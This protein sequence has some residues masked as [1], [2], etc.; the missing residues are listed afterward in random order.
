MSNFANPELR[1]NSLTSVPNFTKIEA[2][3]KYLCEY[4]VPYTKALWLIKVC[5]NSARSAATQKD[6]Y[7][8]GFAD[9]IR[10][11]APILFSRTPTTNNTAGQ[12][13]NA[14]SNAYASN[15]HSNATPTPTKPHSH[16]SN[17]GSNFQTPTKDASHL[18]LS[19]S[20]ATLASPATVIQFPKLSNPGDVGLT[21][22]QIKAK[23]NLLY[24][25]RL[26][27]WAYRDGFIPLGTLVDRFC[28]EF[29]TCSDACACLYLSTLFQFLPDIIVNYPALER[30]KTVLSHV[31]DKFS[32]KNLPSFSATSSLG[33][34]SPAGT[35]QS[36][37]P[38]SASFGSS[39]SG[40][41]SNSGARP[42]LFSLYCSTLKVLV[43]YLPD[44]F[45]PQ[46]LDM[47]R[48]YIGGAFIDHMA[49]NSDCSANSSEPESPSLFMGNGL[50]GVPSGN[51]KAPLPFSHMGRPLT[52]GCTL[53]F[54]AIN[55][56]H[57]TPSQT[58]AFH[59][60]QQNINANRV[61][62]ILDSVCYDHVCTL[63]MNSNFEGI[64]ADSPIGPV[65]RNSPSSHTMG[66]LNALDS[67]SRHLDL[68]QLYTAL[69]LTSQT[70]LASSATSNAGS[71]SG[72][73]LTPNGAV[74]T[75]G[76]VGHRETP[77]TPS[78][79]STSGFVLIGGEALERTFQLICSW[80][81]AP[82][83]TGV[84]RAYVT[85]SLIR[86]Y[87]MS[88]PHCTDLVCDSLIDFIDSL[89]CPKESTPGNGCSDDVLLVSSLLG[90]LIRNRAFS[91]D[92]YLR[93]LI[94]RGI[95]LQANANNPTA[96]KHKAYLL[97][98]PL[99]GDCKPDRLQRS[100][101]IQRYM[102]T[103]K[104]EQDLQEGIAHITNCLLR[105]SSS[106]C[107]REGG[108][109]DESINAPSGGDGGDETP[110]TVSDSDVASAEREL[111][112]Y[113]NSVTLF[114]RC[115]TGQYAISVVKYLLTQHFTPAV[116][117]L[118]TSIVS[119]SSISSSGYANVHGGPLVSGIGV[120]KV[121]PAQSKTSAIGTTAPDHIAPRGFDASLAL[122]DLGPGAEMML[123]QRLC[124]VLEQMAD[125]RSMIDFGRW[126]LDR[127][128]R[129]DLGNHELVSRCL[130]PLFQAYEHVTLALDFSMSPFLERFLILA[131]RCA[132]NIAG[133]HHPSGIHQHALPHAH[134][135]AAAFLVKFSA[136][137]A[138][139]VASVGLWAAEKGLSL[140]ALKR[141]ISPADPPTR[142]AI[143][144]MS[145]HTPPAQS[146]QSLA[147]NNLASGLQ[148]IDGS[149]LLTPSHTSPKIS[150]TQIKDAQELF[151]VLT[152]AWFRRMTFLAQT[153]SFNASTLDSISGSC[154]SSNSLQAIIAHY[155][156][157]MRPSDVR[158]ALGNAICGAKVRNLLSQVEARTEYLLVHW[159][160]SL[161]TWMYLSGNLILGL[162]AK[163][164]KFAVVGLGAQIERSFF[165]FVLLLL[166]TL[167][168][169]STAAVGGGEK[170]NFYTPARW[171]HSLGR[172]IKKKALQTF[173]SFCGLL[174]SY[175]DR[176]ALLAQSGFS[177]SAAISEIKSER[178]QSESD[179][180]MSN[181]SGLGGFVPSS[182]SGGP[183]A[184]SLMWFLGESLL[185][186]PHEDMS[187][188]FRSLGDSQRAFQVCSLIFSNAK[189][190]TM[191]PTKGGILSVATPRSHV[192]SENDD[193]DS[194]MQVDA[195]PTAHKGAWDAFT[196]AID[197]RDI[198]QVEERVNAILSNTHIWSVR[199]T[200]LQ[201]QLLL[202][203]ANDVE[204]Q[205]IAALGATTPNAV[206]PKRVNEIFASAL[207]QRLSRNILCC[208]GYEGESAR[209]SAA[210][211]AMDEDEGSCTFA[212]NTTAARGPQWSE[213]DRLFCEDPLCNSSEATVSLLKRLGAG[214][215]L[216][217]LTY[218]FGLLDPSKHQTTSRCFLS[219]ALLGPE[220]VASRNS[221][222][223]SDRLSA[224][225]VERKLI[226]LLLAIASCCILDGSSPSSSSVVGV[227]SPM[228][229]PSSSFPIDQILE[230]HLNY[231]EEHVM[232][233][234]NSFSKWRTIRTQMYIRLSLIR[235][236]VPSDTSDL[237]AA[238]SGGSSGSSGQNS[239]TTS[240]GASSMTSAAS[241]GSGNGG[242]QGSQGAS[243][244]VD[245]SASNAASIANILDKLTILLLR[246]LASPALQESVFDGRDLWTLA[247][248]SFAALKN[249]HNQ[250]ST[251]RAINEIYP[252][253]TMPSHLRI[254]LEAV[255]QSAAR[256]DR[257]TYLINGSR[258]L[259]PKGI[260]PTRQLEEQPDTTLLNTFGARKVLP[261]QLTYANHL[262][263]SQSGSSGASHS[264]GHAPSHAPSATA[265]HSAQST[266]TSSHSAHS[267]APHHAS[268]P[269]PNASAQRPP[270]SHHSQQPHT[271]QYH[272]QQGQQQHAH[273]P[274]QHQ[275]MQPYQVN[276]IAPQMQNYH[277]GHPQNMAHNVKLDPPSQ[278]VKRPG[279]YDHPAR[280]PPPQPR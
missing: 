229:T 266:S 240:G 8:L 181:A 33:F 78:R 126:L 128:L 236:M 247:L 105:R 253:L 6:D 108:S 192:K 157:S 94:S 61:P 76:G 230:P 269:A 70:N 39:A 171:L 14:T 270:P 92:K 69:F 13:A 5:F 177:P 96:I 56:Y 259:L 231:I 1:V 183:S 27:G 174:A 212:C 44:F 103:S 72:F 280:A 264:S 71:A 246:L 74:N 11:L 224:M 9:T 32:D 121:D 216:D 88:N 134:N 172:P 251:R 136:K 127:I 245:S 277:A 30:F 176:D 175:E 46:T 42:R 234:L 139:K 111:F 66:A 214:V 67:F 188:I 15:S 156:S 26:L 208:D 129:W 60:L 100:L 51:T 202:D 73:K 53:M 38:T 41:S 248:H 141:A 89:P 86:R 7:S 21:E 178:S 271:H 255:I 63:I 219:V 110:P 207:M 118:N 35:A 106:N 232:P 199:F 122:S 218:L 125:F 24:I 272:P 258:M 275:N 93:R 25:I 50:Y 77:Q 90:E 117:T 85:S 197:L 189:S 170:S 58:G 182:P 20:T 19:S 57:L 40:A 145:A 226:D 274:Q 198:S 158:N 16:T 223:D 201:L 131:Q 142:P 48:R 162:V 132:R 165:S 250:T 79:D 260:D 119:A 186:L 113:L 249:C 34:S 149:A 65:G 211:N 18:S 107:K 97:N 233:H 133:A 83:R 64:T 235:W 45:D 210:S 59:M 237:G 163:V 204:R 123:V 195:A 154:G 193:G 104:E 82:F 37:P 180:A 2:L 213:Q 29:A 135:S 84:H 194:G 91:H 155:T 265:H 184:N 187:E 3:L 200:S 22:E 168:H 228:P 49:Q 217:L 109:D 153:A 169:Y 55:P 87:L 225:R 114:C 98:I 220:A 257:P 203:A 159:I 262:L 278:R 238:S 242:S 239:A 112:R 261:R 263:S 12:G 221:G 75:P 267:S 209:S 148:F 146:A 52:G 102:E 130:V 167:A 144:L 244:G 190:P 241:S 143:K 95:L 161:C 47:L 17:S 116:A 62:L 23:S 276:N 173:V 152:E 227:T 101:M 43:A 99:Y 191:P 80:A 115:A 140:D 252:T 151:E 36:H 185:S 150:I 138:A 256:K 68:E 243:R 273:H 160:D 215:R 10:Q 124:V 179:A 4:S 54:S 196:E 206:V 166:A 81:V 28:A 222:E 164:I 31:A 147:I 268:A 279:E 120:N 205:R 254:R 137:N